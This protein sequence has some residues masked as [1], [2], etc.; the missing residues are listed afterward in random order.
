METYRTHG[1]IL[2]GLGGLYDIRLC[3]HAQHAAAHA[4]DAALTADSPMA[5]LTVSCRARGLFRYRGEK[6]LIGDEVCVSY[7]EASFSAQGD[8][9]APDPNG[10]DVVVSAILPRRSAL[11][12]PPMANLDMMLVTMAAASPEP[13]PQMT[14][15]M[16][17]IAEYH[18]IAPVVL[19]TK[20]ELAPACARMLYDIY[21]T[22]GFP[23]FLLREYG[24]EGADEVQDYLREHLR[25]GQTAAFAGT[26]GVG[27]STLLNALFPALELETSEVSR[28]TER[29]RH[30]TRCVTLY[31][32]TNDEDCPYLADTPG[33]SSLD[34]EQFDFFGKDDLPHTMREFAPYLGGCRYT[35][36]SHT[37]E[38]AED[39][40][41]VRAVEAG[42]IP[43]SR[44][45]SYL[46]LY[47]ILK[48]KNDW[49]KK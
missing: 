20:S 28:K 29:G 6:P 5:G 23:V 25:A 10:T 43:R 13:I 12:R 47:D 27:K 15:K 19:I 21:R 42:D 45:D 31:A 2:R 46:A 49:D 24:R 8:T 40:A 17:C 4:A 11:I 22:A 32:T 37:K 48:N 34:F 36:C 44:H 1:K 9:V 16:L 35:N 14:D 18:H 39:C 7:T 26:S 30:T 3:S 41:I 38:S 33:F